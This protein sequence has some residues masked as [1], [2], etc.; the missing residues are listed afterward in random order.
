MVESPASHSPACHGWA[1]RLLASPGCNA[2]GLHSAATRLL[3]GVRWL[4]LIRLSC[5][6]RPHARLVADARAAVSVLTARPV[7]P[8]TGNP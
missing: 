6:R 5:V 2:P 1:R 4:A 8:G 3:V 7:R